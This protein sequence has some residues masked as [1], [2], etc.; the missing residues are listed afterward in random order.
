MLTVTWTNSS[1]WLFIHNFA[2]IIVEKFFSCVKLVVCY[3][4][5]LQ[6]NSCPEEKCTTLQ[7]MQ[8][9]TE[10]RMSMLL[11]TQKIKTHQTI[12]YFTGYC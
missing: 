5:S 2:L 12:A 7:T 10:Y 6:P 11:Y 9:D 3:T 8:V 4:T 1:F